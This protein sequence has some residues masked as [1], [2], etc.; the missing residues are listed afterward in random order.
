MKRAQAV[1][2]AP[3]K[4]MKKKK[5]GRRSTLPSRIREVPRAPLKATVLT[6]RKRR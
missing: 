1:S 6:L 2:V 3:P 5:Y 4:K